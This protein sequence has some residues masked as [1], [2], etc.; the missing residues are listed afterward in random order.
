MK[1][2]AKNKKKTKK[3]M[4]NDQCHRDVVASS[5]HAGFGIA[6][7]ATPGILKCRDYIETD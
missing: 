7:W 5:L 3:I 1:L 4:G 2:T 6:E